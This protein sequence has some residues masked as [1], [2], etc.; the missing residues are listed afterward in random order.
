M[1]VL[2]IYDYYNYTHDKDAKYIFDQGV[3]ALRKNLPLYD[4]NGNSYYDTLRHNAG[5][6]Q[7]VHI[8]LLGRLYDITHAGV[9]KTYHDRWQGFQGALFTK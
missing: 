7:K 8:E 9:F 1:P 2:G 3:L 5:H 4:N 6:T